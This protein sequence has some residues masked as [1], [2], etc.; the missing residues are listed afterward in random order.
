MKKLFSTNDIISFT[1]S[2]VDI[3]YIAHCLSQICRF[4]GGTPRHY[5][6][7][8]HSVIVSQIALNDNEY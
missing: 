2:D 5:S 3:N 7:A 4:A 1:R 6:V 8:E